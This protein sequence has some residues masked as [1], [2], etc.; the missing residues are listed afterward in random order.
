MDKLYLLSFSNRSALRIILVALVAGFLT[1]TKAHA[2]AEQDFI[3]LL[4]E[5]TGDFI[6][7]KTHLDKGDMFLEATYTYTPLDATIS[8]YLEYGST[9]RITSYVDSPRQVLDIAY[10]FNLQQVLDN[11][12]EDVNRIMN[13]GDE[14][15]NRV[16]LYDWQAQHGTLLENYA[17]FEQLPREVGPFDLSYFNVSNPLEYRISYRSDD[18][19]ANLNLNLRFGEL[20]RQQYGSLRC[21][22]Y[23]FNEMQISDYSFYGDPVQGGR[24]L[25]AMNYIDGV[26]IS[27]THRF[28]D[29]PDEET[30]KQRIRELGE[31]IDYDSFFTFEAPPITEPG[32]GMNYLDLSPDDFE[33]FFPAQIDEL[34]LQDIVAYDDLMHLRADYLHEPLDHEIS[35]H[36]AYG[37]YTDR[38]NRGNRLSNF[39]FSIESNCISD[40]LEQNAYRELSQKISDALDE[41]FVTRWEM[42]NLEVG[43]INPLLGLIPTETGS[44]IVHSLGGDPE[45]LHLT[46]EYHHRG[47][48]IPVT[49][50][51]RYGDEA[52]QQ[53]NRYQIIGFEENR[54]PF[55][56]GGLRFHSMKADNNFLAFTYDDYRL[57]EAGIREPENIDDIAG[58]NQNL[59]NFFDE[60]SPEPFLTW[61]PPEDYEMEFDGT[62]P[63]GTT[64]CL[65]PECMD[66]YL[67]ECEPAGFGGRLNW[68]LGVLYRIEEAEDN[69]K[70]RLSMQYTRNPNDDWVEKPLYFTLDRNE[71]FADSVPQIV[72]QC[73]EGQSDAHNCTGPLMDLILED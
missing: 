37:D 16:E 38:L 11:A 54:H 32:M 59:I 7:E 35:V 34:Q 5:N 4:H 19:E 9:E 70:C 13:S 20:A 57:I 8:F 28:L 39:Q 50:S 53:Y 55:E 67:I 66:Q 3:S 46:A 48:Q 61:Q 1:N 30:A 58:L 15:F 2:D 44:Y 14:L 69:Q 42:Q 62:L 29:N 43:N 40:K 18:V 73:M 21:R 31:T 25:S 49:L 41:G 51:M 33:D 47:E 63:D 26:M 60:V 56:A 71:N 17:F 52:V 45:D 68:Q 65:D 22:M 6:L 27:M 10:G 36:L 72:E 12:R 24:V 64:H 23:D